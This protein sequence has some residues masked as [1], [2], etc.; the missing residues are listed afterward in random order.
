M[1]E[2]LRT[3]LFIVAIGIVCYNIYDTGLRIENAAI[4]VMVIGCLMLNMYTA[5]KKRQQQEAEEEAIREKEE[6][7]RIRMENR[8]KSRRKNRRKAR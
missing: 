1:R 2:R 3:V 6:I 4:A 7:R 8:Q 5:N